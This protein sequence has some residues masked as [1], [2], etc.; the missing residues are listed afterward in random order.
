MLGGLSLYRDDGSNIDRGACGEVA[1]IHF[2]VSTAESP[3]SARICSLC[4]AKH[5][6]ISL[7]IVKKHKFIQCYHVTLTGVLQASTASSKRR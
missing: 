5:N 7:R 3:I 6:H 4:S 1:A 2:D